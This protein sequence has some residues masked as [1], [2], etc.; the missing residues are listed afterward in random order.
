M[1]NRLYRYR[2]YRDIYR[3]TKITDIRSSALLPFRRFQSLKHRR[4]ELFFSSLD[5]YNIRTSRKPTAG[6]HYSISE[7]IRLGSFC[8]AEGWCG[9]DISGRYFA[10]PVS[11]SFRRG[12][13]IFYQLFWVDLT[14]GHGKSCIFFCSRSDAM[15]GDRACASVARI[16]TAGAAFRLTSVKR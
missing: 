8:I 4:A 9:S 1:H 2:Y 13:C 16:K 12:V 7:G 11:N 5:V 10:S 14:K 3:D 6:L 15:R